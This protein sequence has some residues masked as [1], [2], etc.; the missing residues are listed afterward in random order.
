MAPQFENKRNKTK[1]EA[2]PA[3]KDVATLA[4]SL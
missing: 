1:T 2:K 3:I 4:R